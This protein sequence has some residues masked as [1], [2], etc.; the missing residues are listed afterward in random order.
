MAVRAPVAVADPD[1]VERPGA[2]DAP[3]AV[4]DE[5][6][7]GQEDGLRVGAR[8]GRRG[9]SVRRLP[10]RQR[11]QH[12]VGRAHAVGALAPLAGERDDR[13]VAAQRRPARPVVGREAPRLRRL[14]VAQP[15]VVAEQV[16]V[17]AVRDHHAPRGGRRTRST[18]ACR[19][20]R[21]VA[22]ACG[23]GRRSAGSRS[24]RA[25]GPGRRCGRARMPPRRRAGRSPGTRSGSGSAAPPVRLSR[26]STV[27]AAAARIDRRAG[28]AD[29]PPRGRGQR[30]GGAAVGAKRLARCRRRSRP[31]S[32]EGW[33]PRRRRR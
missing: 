6:P 7:V 25:S 31:G 4:A 20:R 29:R 19:R 3:A 26:M 10:G 23:S 8:A 12:D 18:A 28:V 32:G 16:D 13:A 14:A 15:D 17:V 2:A 27:V 24:S 9:T 1:E 22:G 30:G 21:P 5:Q 11:Q 33:P